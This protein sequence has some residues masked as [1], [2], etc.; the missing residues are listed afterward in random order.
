MV[1]PLPKTL[2]KTLA[3]NLVKNLA[4]NLGGEL[5]LPPAVGLIKK[6][7]QKLS[8]SF[9]GLD[10][11]FYIKF[12]PRNRQE[13]FFDQI[14]VQIFGQVFDQVFGKGFDQVLGKENT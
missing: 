1:F 4:K 2:V 5:F 7:I 3:K 10:S 13:R 11:G 6:Q 8:S 14:F 9:W 12:P